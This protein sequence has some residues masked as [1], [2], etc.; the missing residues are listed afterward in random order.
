[1]VSVAALLVAG[2]TCGRAVI[3]GTWYPFGPALAAAAYVVR[4]ASAWAA[5]LGACLA[6]LAGPRPAPLVEVAARVGVTIAVLVAMRALAIGE[7]A[8]PRFGAAWVTAVLTGLACTAVEIAGHGAGRGVA[9]WRALGTGLASGGAAWALVPGLGLIDGAAPRGRR[10]QGG[11]ARAVGPFLLAGLCALGCTGPGV[12]GVD[13]GLVG[14]GAL[15]AVVAAAG[16][17]AVGAAGGLLCGLL[18]MAGGAAAAT[19]ALVLGAGGLL[20]GAL[21]SHGRLA[22][23]GAFWVG[24]LAAAALA[25]GRTAFGWTAIAPAAI[26]AGAAA[27]ILL[28]LPGAAVTTA[29]V[30]AASSDGAVAATGY[31]ATRLAAAV[32]LQ[33]LAAAMRDLSR[34]FAPGP[35]GAPGH[36]AWSGR[37][38]AAPAAPS[39]VEI[40]VERVCRGCPSCAA[41]WQERFHA[42]YRALA[43]YAQAAGRGDPGGVPEVGGGIRRRC[44]RPSALAAAAALAGEA[45]DAQERLARAAAEAGGVLAAQLEGI[46]GV[47][48]GLAN[49]LARPPRLRAA[50]PIADGSPPL[51]ASWAGRAVS[52]GGGAAD[53]GYL[54]REV[55]PGRLLA[56]VSGDGRAT[57]GQP[58]VALRLLERLAACGINHAAAV[59]AVSS[60]L[61]LRSFSERVMPLDAV[62]IDLEAGRAEFIKVGA[63]PSFL[64]RGGD[65][66]ELAA[67]AAPTSG[68]GRP[69]V[70]RTARTLF[71]G[72]TL[73]MVSAGIV[74]PSMGGAGHRPGARWLGDLLAAFPG[75]DPGALVG[76]VLE[77]ALVR[78]PGQRATDL[79]AVAICIAAN[80]GPAP[81]AGQGL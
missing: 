75:G 36:D 15:T 3:L 21:R 20:G 19:D 59:A 10:A 41:C 73:L 14:L 12:Q 64:R 2:F 57:G 8:R 47:V 56:A 43:A 61:L 30:L 18:G 35:G 74:A 70:Y 76:G 16:G 53:S 79:V 49:D 72:D 51:A 6:C 9:A 33:Q 24:A 39:P 62:M 27:T 23:A 46:A 25:A 32:E 38:A 4:P 63:P 65:A 67:P 52:A 7:L 28:L 69:E 26:E 45:S 37:P 60:A 17:P 44:L 34:A 55:G 1:M 13:L 66:E 22:V 31:T 58:A 81:V 71:A 68:G 80:G 54:V 50:A 40:I 77:G 11:V 78:Q 29:R 42:S 5:A 48:A